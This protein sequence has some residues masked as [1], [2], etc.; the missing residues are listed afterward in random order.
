M[1]HTKDDN[2]WLLI[3][4]KTG[5][6]FSPNTLRFFGS[7]I[8]WHTLTEID[9]GYLFITAEDN[10]NAT[11]RRF[12][13]RFVN[14]DFGIETLGEFMGYATLDHAKTALKNVAGFAQFV[15]KVGA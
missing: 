6:F 3:R 1:K 7:R 12:S 2:T 5:F 13:V 14:A 8:Y 9:G 10:W 15:E 4:A 11:E